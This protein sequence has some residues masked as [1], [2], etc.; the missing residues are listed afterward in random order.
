MEKAGPGSSSGCSFFL[1]GLSTQRPD[2]VWMR[3][4]QSDQPNLKSSFSP[5]LNIAYKGRLEVSEL[6]FFSI[7]EKKKFFFFLIT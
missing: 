3:T 4:W 2:K 5:L 7:V 1:P 6:P